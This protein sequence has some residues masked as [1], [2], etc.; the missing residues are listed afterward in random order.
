VTQAQALLALGRW[1][2]VH[3]WI[4]SLPE[5]IRNA[6]PWLQFWLG[7]C[8]LRVDPAKARAHLE[9]AFDLFRKADDKLGQ[10]LAAAAMIET[11][12][13][14]WIDYSQFDPWIAAL[15]MLLKR[16]DIL[17]PSMDTELA[18]R[19]SLFHAIVLRQSYREDLLD[20]A[21]QLAAMLRH[22]LDPNYKLLA[23]RALLLYG[24]YSGEF[25]LSEEVARYTT[26]ALNAP[27]ATA[28]NR[29]WY[30][31]RRAFGLRYTESP[32]K[33]R[34]LFIQARELV[35][36]NG[37]RFMEVPIATLWAWSEDVFDDI[38]GMERELRIVK[39][40][41]NSASRFEVAFSHV[42][43]ALLSIRYNDLDAT[44]VHFQEAIAFFRQ[45]GSTIAQAMALHALSAVLLD[46]HRMEEAHAA[47]VEA[48]PLMICGSLTRYASALSQAR[49]ALRCKDEDTAIEQLRLAL[50]L[51]AK[52]GLETAFS[53]C[54]YFC[55]ITELCAF[56]L[57]HG[58]ETA[59]VKRII[60]SQ[61]LHAPSP[62]IE[63]WP[64]PVR[65]RALGGFSLEIE[66][67]LVSF[68]GKAPKKPLE[69]LKALVATGGTE[70]DI[71]W[72]G[73]QLWPDA[74]GDAARAV[75]HVTHSRLR[76]LLPLDDVLMLSEGKLR[77]NPA[78]VWTDVWAFERAAEECLDKVRR[79]AERS[80]IETAGETLLSLYTGD[81]LKGEP[82]SPW[83]IVA[84]DRLR[85]KFLRTLKALGGFWETN[86]VWDKAHSL[87]ERVLEI[88]N[89]AEEVY[90]RLMSCYIRSGRPAE[91]LRVYRRCRQMLSLVLGIAPSAET[92]T[93]CRSID[94]AQ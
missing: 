43:R 40:H 11:Y 73:E 56:A 82:D 19:A 27:G 20:L 15:E 17:F 54:F 16:D 38:T 26:S 50:P 89:V 2:T 24:A 31:T 1:Q 51:A 21:K 68:S 22:D 25:A 70:V 64:W 6:T 88:D 34:A 47:L 44:I 14:E 18:V 84:R 60:R 49:L 23:A 46:K 67:R 63:D 45:S 9:S 75:F 80:G 83:L 28:M 85:S 29:A 13:T 8:R 79:S 81:L 58:V 92:E 76:K 37:L 32:D 41:L 69:L 33:V 30:L 61:H 94:Q 5:A 65:I 7:M 91:A 77:L 10:V 90:R 66:D 42:G 87:Y 57:K 93:L 71:G 52:Y 36:S 59:C 55:T 53:E 4:E 39:E 3:Q 86:A 72:L 74:E 62:E 35:R 78:H 12:A 48:L